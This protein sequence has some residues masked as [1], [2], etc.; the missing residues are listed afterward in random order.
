MQGLTFAL[1]GMVPQP[2]CS[3]EGFSVSI[4]LVLPHCV[5]LQLDLPPVQPRRFLPQALCLPQVCAVHVIAR[6]GRRTVTRAL[7]SIC[8][9]L[10]RAH[11]H[12]PCSCAYA[13]L[14]WPAVKQTTCN[15]LYPGVLNFHCSRVCLYLRLCCCICA[16]PLAPS[17]S[18]L[19]ASSPGCPTC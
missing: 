19:R 18:S 5:S 11:T 4:V 9:S 13:A 6:V 2:V 12:S 7:I 16:F 14:S 15:A 1:L 17:H 8:L 10:T 3:L